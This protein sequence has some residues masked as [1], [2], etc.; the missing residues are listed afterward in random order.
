MSLIILDQ[1]CRTAAAHRKCVQDLIWSSIWNS[2]EIG[3][4]AHEIVTT[5]IHKTIRGSGG[6]QWDGRVHWGGPDICLL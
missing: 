6:G 2:I 5:T 3:G 4:P 1:E